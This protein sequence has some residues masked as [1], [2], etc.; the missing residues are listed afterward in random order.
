[1]DKEF[2]KNI[3]M[4]LGSKNRDTEIT[5]KFKRL[6]I[7]SKGIGKLAGLGIANVMRIE[8]VKDGKK[9]I[10]EIDRRLIRERILDEVDFPIEELTTNEKN[11]TTVILKDLLS[12]VKTIN[13]EELRQFLAR[14]FVSKSNFHVWVNGEEIVLSEIPNVERRN[15]KENI[16]GCGPVKGYILIADKPSTLRSYKL[17]PGIV[18]TVRGRR[19]F[20]P[21][22]FDINSYGHWYRVAERIYGEIEVPSFD[23]ET[24]DNEIDEFII[25]TSRDGVNK[26]HPK[27]LKYKEWIERKL[28]EICRRLEKEQAEGRKRKILESPEFKKMLLRIPKEIR[29]DVENKVKKMI[30]ELVPKLNELPPTKAEAVIQVISKLVES[31]EMITLLEKIEE[32]SKEDVKRLSKTLQDWGIYEVNIVVEHFKSRLAVISKFEKLIENINTLEYP[33]IH[34]LFE[35]NLW[36]LND[37]YRLYASNK[38]LRKLLNKEIQNKYKKHSKDRPDL[39]VKSF[40]KKVIIIEL[41]RPAHKVCAEDYTQIKKYKTIIKKHSPNISQIEC[42]LIGNSFDEAIR[43]PEDEKIGIYLWSYSEIL[44]KAKEKY[45]ELLSKLQME[46]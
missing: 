20:G 45:L 13:D 21:T 29:S 12:H 41:K 16:D 4:N 22:L 15:I 42:Y 39:I 36:L 25:S 5:P 2:I 33:D 11:G 35:K 38:Q 44:Q 18:T 27:Y 28:I 34:K 43:D 14:E 23:P 24:P 46:V 1:M 10:F 6:K 19:L 30:E 37:E 26:N 7:G 17:K 31:G 9:C 8:T 40:G 3:Y 32:A